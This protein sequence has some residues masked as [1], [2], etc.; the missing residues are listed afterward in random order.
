MP[1]AAA[2][3]YAL[4]WALVKR[5]P[6]PLA[7]A[8]FDGAADLAWRR[9]SRGVQRLE[10]NLRRAAPDAT[11]AALRRLS[12]AGMRSYLRYWRELFRLP[13]MSEADIRARMRVSG[14]RRIF[15]TLAA[16]RPVIL[17]LPHMGNWDHAGAWCVAQGAPFTT[18]AERLE[19]A[20]VFDAFV[21]AREALGMEVLPV[22]AGDGTGPYRVLADRLRAG[23]MVCLLA[24]RDMT[25]SGVPVTLL[26]ERASM[27]AGPAAL[28]LETGAALLPV[29]LWF[30]EDDDG[31]ELW[32][33]RVHDDVRDGLPDETTATVPALTQR[34]AD[35]FSA[36]ITEH[37]ADWHMLQRVFTDDLPG[38]D[39]R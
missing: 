15:D 12:R 11:G 5:L 4:G 32:H 9:Q 22:A 36:A 30:D 17:A 16:G 39:H 26:G 24:D 19:P 20:E 34:L 23:R 2:A 37:P 28:A 13:A 8:I 35:V 27:P 33:A 14:Q 10:V 29:S 31:T 18:V 21:A 38:A 6:D 25:A 1:T 7:R 3:G